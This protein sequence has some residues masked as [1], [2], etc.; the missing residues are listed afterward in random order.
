MRAVRALGVA[1]AIAVVSLSGAAAAVARTPVDPTSLTP[2]L[3][4]FRVCYQLGPYVQCDTSGDVSNVN[5]EIDELPCGALYSTD[6]E[7]SHSTRWYVDGLMVR[8]QVQEHIAGTFSLSPAG[9]APSVAYTVDDSW[10]QQFTT[11]GD[12]DTAVSTIRGNHITIP[13][14]GADW[15]DAGLILPDDSVRGHFTGLDPNAAI[16]LCAILED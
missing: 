12:L 4:P 6:R 9:D 1:I 5:V 2:P 8:R 7:V 11:P 10:D 13:A 3:K 15:H 14:I 16:Q